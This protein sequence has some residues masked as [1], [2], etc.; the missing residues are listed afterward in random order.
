MALMSAY[1]TSGGGLVP[2]WGG[3]AVSAT[4]VVTGVYEV[5]FV[6]DIVGC[7]ASV[8]AVVTPRAVSIYGVTLDNTGYVVHVRDAAGE[9]VNS[10]FFITVMCAR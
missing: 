10:Q 6:R 4:R 7:P 9:L 5:Y 8:T 2:S 3:G 1:V